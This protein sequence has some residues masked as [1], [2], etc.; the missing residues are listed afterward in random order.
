LPTFRDLT[1]F[2]RDYKSLPRRFDESEERQVD[3]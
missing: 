2:P 1:D 3:T